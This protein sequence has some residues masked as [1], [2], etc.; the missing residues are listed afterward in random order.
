[1]GR[2]INLRHLDITFTGV[3]R[4]PLEMGNLENLQT[5]T[6]FV[7]GKYSGCTIWLLKDLQNL[8]GKLCFRGLENIAKVEDVLV[9]NLK[10]IKFL[11]EIELC[12]SSDDS[13]NNSLIMHRDVLNGL[14]PHI[15]L[16]DLIIIG[17]GG[18]KFPNWVGHPSF[19]NL[20]K[21]HLEGCRECSMLPPFGQLPFLKHLRI[22]RF[23]EVVKI[24]NEF[25]CGGCSVPTRPFRCLKSL[26]I[27][28]MRKCEEWSFNIEEDGDA[29]FPEL[30]TF[31]LI[32]CPRLNLYMCFPSMIRGVKIDGCR[33][34]DLSRK[35]QQRYKN[36]GKLCIG[37]CEFIDSVVLDYF[38]MFTSLS[39]EFCGNLKSLTYSQQPPET[40]SLKRLY[41]IGC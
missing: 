35:K 34:F 2:L 25:Y 39:L 16:K 30:A 4:M 23:D 5:L 24:G 27:Y 26:N 17:Y 22:S 20:E 12:W 11:K 3:E 15:I 21:I 9:A 1:M 19:S 32:N 37:C 31:T 40:L 10:E 14:E 33:K 7:V 41:L 18:E 36:S 28:D 6:K 13:G 38:P 8:H 29:A